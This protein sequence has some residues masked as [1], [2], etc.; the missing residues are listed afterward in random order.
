MQQQSN[1]Q[2]KTVLGSSAHKD[3]SRGREGKLTGAALLQKHRNTLG[4]GMDSMGHS[5][6][7]EANS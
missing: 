4:G 6:Q 2:L 3:H 5:Y 7:N 1:N